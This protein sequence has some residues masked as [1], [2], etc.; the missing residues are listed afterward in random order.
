MV[1]DISQFPVAIQGGVAATLSPVAPQWATFMFGAETFLV[2]SF[3]EK[4]VAVSR[5]LGVPEKIPGNFAGKLLNLNPRLGSTER[6][7]QGN[8][9]SGQN[10]NHCLETTVNR[11]LEFK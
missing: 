7:G 1:V 5:V 2:W 3:F 11:P 9:I 6:G 8:S 4:A 10:S